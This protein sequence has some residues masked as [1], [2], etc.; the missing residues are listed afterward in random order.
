MV[1]Q[2]I[3]ETA[4]WGGVLAGMLALG[5]AGLFP[6]GAAALPSV[7]EVLAQHV[8]AAGG[9]T[10][11]RRIKTRHLVG[12]ATSDVFGVAHWELLGKAPDKRLTTTEITGFGT[13][14]DGY[15]GKVAWSQNPMI[16]IKIR[17]GEEAARARR[18]ADFY[19]DLNLKRLY[20]GL[21]VVG[22][23]KVGDADTWLLESHPSSESV[24]RFFFSQRSGRLLQ[25]ESEYRDQNGA[26]RTRTRFADFRSVDGVLIPFHIE[27]RIEQPN[28]GE[29]TLKLVLTKVE[30]NLKVDDA[31][32]KFPGF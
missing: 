10:A 32:F 25:H 2:V 18:E 19:Q 13:L 20:P 27:L 6:V 28:T 8:K 11:L 29:F 14:L 12:T 24:D 5:G 1:I 7:D 22:A 30:H 3:R 31:K 21:K 15:D 9:E 26:T 16:G 4:S 17:K 23:A